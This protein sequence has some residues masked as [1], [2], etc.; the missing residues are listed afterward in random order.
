MFYFT[1]N[2]LT[3]CFHS[4]NMNM[5]TLVCVSSLSPRSRLL[6]DCSSALLNGGYKVSRSHTISGSLKSDAPRSFALDLIRAW[7]ETH[8][9]RMDKVAEKSPTR[10]LLDKPKT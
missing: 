8:P 9:I 10:V 2:K 1:A 6:T 7:V 5:E 4:E 3:S